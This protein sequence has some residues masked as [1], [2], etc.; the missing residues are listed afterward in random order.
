MSKTNK[1]EEPKQEKFMTKYDRKMEAR[2][3]KE[4]KD[5]R[6]N[7]V[8][9]IVGIVVAVVFVGA[10]AASVGIGAY[11]KHKVL[12]KTFV[13]VGN[14]EIAKLEYDFYYNTMLTNYLNSFSAYLPYMGLDTTQDFAQQ[15]YDENRTWQDLFDEMAIGQITETKALADDAEA[16]GFVYDTADEDYQT[17]REG[18][19]LQADNA[20]VTLSEYY[21]TAFGSYATEA[22]VEPFVRETYLASA[23]SSK[24]LED[25]KPSEEEI[26]TRYEENKQDYDH[27]DYYMYTFTTD[28]TAESTEEETRAAMEEAKQKADAMKEE[29]LAGEDFQALCD[30]YDEKDNGDAEADE[31]AAST[32]LVENATYNSL[33]SV[34]ADW[35]Y[36]EAR[37]EGDIDTFENESTNRVYV[38][39]FVNRTSRDE[40]TNDTI[41]SQIASER[42]SAYTE[43]L[44]AKYEI[45]DVAGDLVYLTK[46]ASSGDS[47]EA[48]DGDES[49]PEEDAGEEGSAGEEN[50]AKDDQTEDEG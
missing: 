32:N 6:D 2:K 45:T 20:G 40:T 3:L 29:R 41:S 1:T 28:V 16:A 8:S 13:K 36:D 23:Y 31:D 12:S 39:E 17:F 50:Q 11:N 34:F 5:K 37:K 26:T 19:Q 25:N 35:L 9:K 15:Q 4:Q 48:N 49:Q 42:V 30:K 22:R 43:E 24:L 38:V 21:K 14:H 18:V 27:V 47:A 10:I 46:P 33:Y 7:L 44:K